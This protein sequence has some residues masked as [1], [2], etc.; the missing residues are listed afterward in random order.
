MPEGV[1]WYLYQ[2]V[3]ASMD[4]TCLSSTYHRCSIDL[5][6]GEFGGQL[7][8][9]NLLLCPSNHFWTIFALWHIILLKEATVVG[10]CDFHERAILRYVVRVKVISTWM[11]RPK[12]S[13]Q[14][15]GQ[16]ITLSTCLAS[17]HSRFGAMCSS[18]KRHKHTHHL[19]DAKWKCK[20]QTRA[21][22]SIPLSSFRE[23]CSR[24]HCSC[25][26]QWT[27]VSMGTLIDLRLTNVYSDIFPSESELTF[28]VIWA[29]VA[30]LLHYTTQA[31]LCSLPPL[32]RL[33]H[34]WPCRWFTTVSLLDHCKLGTPHMSC[35]FGPYA[36]MFF[37]LLTHQ[38]W[39][40]IVLFLHK[41]MSPT[42]ADTISF[43][44]IFLLKDLVKS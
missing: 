42:Q 6:S 7:K 10:E 26:H 23:W 4:R 43:Y 44:L 16:S 35:S 39:G 27:G 29:T 34:S 9:S 15:I 19:H 37:L 31:R 25:I 21:P 2:D 28:M 5:R 14:N 22:S 1:L 33:G 8:T 20:C 38:L 36:C 17:F 41:Y 30:C 18:E 24:A 13:Q 11:P 3:E 32:L 40:Q 12:L